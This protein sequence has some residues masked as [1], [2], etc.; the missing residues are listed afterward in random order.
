MILDCTGNTPICVFGNYS[1]RIK[2]VNASMVCGR[3]DLS[4]SLAASNG[5]AQ[6]CRE[7]QPETTKQPPNFRKN[8]GV[9]GLQLQH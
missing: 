2:Y 4:K 8:R 7:K 9:E 3:D 1:F 5:V 6:L